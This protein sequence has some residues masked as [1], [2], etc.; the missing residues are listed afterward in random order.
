MNCSHKYDK[1]CYY[2]LTLFIKLL[3]I[4]DCFLGTAYVQNYEKRILAIS[5]NNIFSKADKVPRSMGKNIAWVVVKTMAEKKN[6]Y[7]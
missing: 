6:A 5:W 1:R 2:I 3:I 7:S 4:C